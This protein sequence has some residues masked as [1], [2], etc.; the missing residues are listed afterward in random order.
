MAQDKDGEAPKAAHPERTAKGDSLR[1]KVGT[2]LLGFLLTGVVGTMV[3]TWFQQRGWAWQ[4]RVAQVEKDTTSA[5]EL[6]ALGVRPSRQALVRDVPD[7]AGNAD[8]DGRRL[9]EGG[10]GQ[11]SHGQQ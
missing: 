10:E 5:L 11:V 3:A 6:A 2:A 1:E 9:V 4:N 8:S 7:A